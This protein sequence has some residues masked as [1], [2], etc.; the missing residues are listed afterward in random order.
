MH[1]D[2]VEPYTEILHTAMAEKRDYTASVRLKNSEGAYQYFDVSAHWMPTQDDDRPDLIGFLRDVTDLTESRAQAH[3]S[4]RIFHALSENMPAAVF[5]KGLDGVY[6]YG[7]ELAAAY[8]GCTK[9]TF[10]GRTASDIFG[11]ETALALKAVDEH[12][13]STG[14]SISRQDTFE[15]QSG[16]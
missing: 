8:V 9:E 3:R 6:I 5:I 11:V 2:D 1:P 13:I 14:G 15:T 4:E 7:N 16:E 10:I 12:L